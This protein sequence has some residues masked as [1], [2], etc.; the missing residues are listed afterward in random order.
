MNLTLQSHRWNFPYVDQRPKF[1]I[2]QKIEKNV[3]GCPFLEA[4][5]LGRIEM[6]Q[7]VDIVEVLDWPFMALKF[8]GFEFLARSP[9]ITRKH[10]A[11][12][13]G[14]RLYFAFFCVN[15][16][17]GQ[18][19][20]LIH[21][22]RSYNQIESFITVLAGVVNM[23][24]LQIKIA[25]MWC[26]NLKII[27]TLKRW[28]RIDTSKV[29][30]ECS[31]QIEKLLKAFRRVEMVK[32]VLTVSAVSFQCLLPIIR[33]LFFNGF[34]YNEL[35][36]KIWYPLDVSDETTF[37]IT[38]C[39][40]FWIFFNFGLLLFAIEMIIYGLI[41]TV[42]IHFKI[43]THE[44]VKTIALNGNL[45]PLVGRHCELIEIAHQLNEIFSKVF[46]TTLY[47]SSS[48]MCV[49]AYMATVSNDIFSLAK[50]L[51]FS[52]VV[53]FQILFLCHLG[54]LL[55]D[56]SHEIFDA[57]LLSKWYEKNKMTRLAVRM[58]QMQALRPCKLK[59]WKFVSLNFSALLAVLSTAFSYYTLL[60]SLKQNSF[61]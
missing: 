53:T 2:E 13:Y 33:F 37:N 27:Q 38:F 39:W 35:P 40:T 8:C 58:M 16:V 3:R 19:C 1:I 12:F 49:A 47:G 42:S 56:S 5:V 29:S 32:V 45:K 41:M 23:H 15:F 44:I 6:K 20:Q 57:I 28:G 26:R 36:W 10:K 46:L 61:V 60:K 4:S 51:V 52:V 22:T 31:A 24:G 34:W 59:A 21:L 25:T 9:G 17:L 43:L 50:Y 54:N 14:K 55:L 18:L 7:E 30:P 11:I 48:L